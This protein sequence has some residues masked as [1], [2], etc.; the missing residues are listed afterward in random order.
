MDASSDPP[1][2]GSI[3][4][5]EAAALGQPPVVTKTEEPTTALMVD[6]SA[7]AGLKID[8]G[9]SNGEAK[10]KTLVSPT[11]ATSAPAT[12]TTAPTPTTATTPEASTTTTK[13]ANGTT[14]AASSTSSTPAPTT[15]DYD[16]NPQDF[17]G[18]VETNNNLP[19]RETLRKLED[20]TVLDADGKSVPFKSLYTGHNVARRVLIIFIRHFFC[21]NCQEYLRTLANSITPEALLGLPL[22]TFIAVV[23]CGAP[24]LINTYINET[25]CPFPVYADPTRRLYT[26]L[27]MVRTLYMGSRPAY[28]QN[29]SIT[30]TIVSG[31]V[32]GLKQVKSGLALK[33][34]D[35][36]QVGGEFLF[37]P[38]SNSLETP[39]PTP[40][41]EPKTLD[42]DDAANTHHAEK[43]E[44][45]KVTWCHRM[46]TTRDHCEIPELMEVLGL[47]GEGRPIQDAKRWEKALKTR[48]GTGLSMAS[49][50]SRMSMDAKAATKVQ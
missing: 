1:A 24:E 12:R 43:T 6:E 25:S 44:E 39:L 32:Q 11:Q 14:N 42:L 27:G 37:E 34:G 36:R 18:E 28:M 2:T 4:T 49:Q 40:M 13:D 41:D 3:P 23:G 29:K 47:D 16:V 31:V 9:N 48:K 10:T 7:P 20:H 38:A 50:M 30:H 19:S 26:E 17:A 46:R 33:M 21:G 22:S 5:V 35:S 8:T 45:K 15:K